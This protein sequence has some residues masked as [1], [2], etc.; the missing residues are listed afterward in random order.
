[1]QQPVIP[2]QI[3]AYTTQQS[4]GFFYHWHHLVLDVVSKLFHKVL[5]NRLV[6]H[7]ESNGFLHTAQNA[8]RSGR[9]TDDHVYCLS[10]VVKGR[11]RGGGCQRTP[12]SWIMSVRR[13]IQCGGMACYTK[14]CKL[15]NQ[16]AVD[17]MHV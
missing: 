12:S 14:A 4:W 5:A 6:K 8:F 10:E 16:E 11:H 7:A 15:W 3:T 1:M 13:M 2:S 9:S 17:V